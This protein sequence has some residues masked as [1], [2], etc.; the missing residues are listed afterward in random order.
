MNTTT[1]PL[2]KFCLPQLIKIASDYAGGMICISS[3]G[4]SVQINPVFN[5][6]LVS[7]EEAVKLAAYIE[8]QVLA[9][10]AAA[11]TTRENKK[12]A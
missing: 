3:F 8:E 10:E 7:T 4:D 1:S 2:F 11:L 5:A 9:L 6:N 12:H